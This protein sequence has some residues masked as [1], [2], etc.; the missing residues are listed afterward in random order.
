MTVH[1]ISHRLAV[2]DP[3]T[4]KMI[5]PMLTTMEGYLTAKVKEGTRIGLIVRVKDGEPVLGKFTGAR[6]QGISGS[7]VWSA[8]LIYHLFRVPP[9]RLGDT[10][11]AVA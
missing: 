9:S 11:E 10:F 8:T 3:S 6:I 1:R 2:P 5:S 7:Y 4:L